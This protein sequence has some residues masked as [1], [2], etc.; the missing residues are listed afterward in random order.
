MGAHLS[1]SAETMKKKM[2][3]LKKIHG[4]VKFGE[5]MKT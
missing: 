1:G 4:P 5:W 3:K 2:S